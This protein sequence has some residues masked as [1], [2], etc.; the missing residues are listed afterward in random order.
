MLLNVAAALELGGGPETWSLS[1]L[2]EKPGHADRAGRCRLT[3]AG[4]APFFA[5]VLSDH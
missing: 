1:A 2:L 3:I 5:H 4:R